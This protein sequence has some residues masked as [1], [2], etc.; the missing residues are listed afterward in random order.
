M[1]ARTLARLE[2][3]LFG[4][5]AEVTVHDSGAVFPPEF[6]EAASADCKAER[7]PGSPNMRA[8]EAANVRKLQASLH[9]YK[10]ILLRRTFDTI[11]MLVRDRLLF[12]LHDRLASDLLLDP[13]LL[14][15]S[16]FEES[17]HVTER[18]AQTEKL[19]QRL[20]FALQKLEMAHD[21]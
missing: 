11:P 13:S 2:Q 3:A 14:Q 9:V 5:G 15:P 8:G 10:C 18:R 4:D 21:E 7:A 19:E 6:L 1:Y 16:L 20:T 12:T 17:P